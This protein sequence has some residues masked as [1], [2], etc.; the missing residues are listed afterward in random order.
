MLL[1]PS[2]R[3][4]DPCRIGLVRVM[5]SSLVCSIGGRLWLFTVVFVEF[6]RWLAFL[7]AVIVYTYTALT[8]LTYISL[9]L[10]SVRDIKIRLF[11]TILDVM[12][13]TVT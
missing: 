10:H 2:L 4:V 13:Y 9:L 7:G 1:S 8:G 5:H 3:I 12:L 6:L 11:T